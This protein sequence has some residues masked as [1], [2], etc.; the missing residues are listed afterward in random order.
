MITDQGLS[1]ATPAVSKTAYRP[2]STGNTGAANST[3]PGPHAAPTAAEDRPRVFGEPG[4]INAALDGPVA[5][6]TGHG[7]A[8]THAAVRPAAAAA[9]L[10]REAT[11]PSTDPTTPAGEGAHGTEAPTDGHATRAVPTPQNQRTPAA[12]HDPRAVNPTRRPNA[13][14]AARAGSAP[15]PGTAPAA[16][17]RDVDP[18]RPEQRVPSPVPAQRRSSPP[19]PDPAVR[20]APDPGSPAHQ[21]PAW[22][23]DAARVDQV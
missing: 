9:R 14:P 8:L 15:G 19:D 17:P 10:P 1:T 22:T 2:A 12:Q 7:P 16:H 13:Q 5:A 21:A 11:A 23:Q 3:P 4:Y 6:S 18:A 20:I